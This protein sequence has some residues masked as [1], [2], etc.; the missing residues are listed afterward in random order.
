ML[1]R[2]LTYTEAAQL[3]GKTQ[4]AVRALARRQHWPR[5]SPNLP[6]GHARVRVPENLALDR[7]RPALPVGQFDSDRVVTVGQVAGQPDGR[8]QLVSAF[9]RAVTALQQQLDWARH[10]ID[11]LEVDLADTRSAERIASAN[12]RALHAQAD[13]RRGWG[14]LRRLRWA[15]KGC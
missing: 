9:D 7:P 10:R 13:T 1:E 14:L 3:L 15:L 8:D 5:Q 11:A 6:G 4:E 2:W 12:V